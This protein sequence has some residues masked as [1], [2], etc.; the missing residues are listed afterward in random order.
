M[1]FRRIAASDFSFSGESNPLRTTPKIYFSRRSRSSFFFSKSSELT[2]AWASKL[3]SLSVSMLSFHS[4]FSSSGIPSF[5]RSNSTTKSYIASWYFTCSV[6]SNF[7][8]PIFLISTPSFMGYC[9]LIVWWYVSYIAMQ[10]C[11]SISVKVEHPQNG[12]FFC[13]P[14]WWRLKRWPFFYPPLWRGLKRWPFFASPSWW[15]PKRCHFLLFRR[16]WHLNL[17][18][19]GLIRREG[20][21]NL[22]GFG[23]IHR[24]D[25]QNSINFGPLYRGD[26][27]NSINFGPLHRGY[28]QNSINFGPL[29]RGDVQNSIN[30]GPLRRG[31]AQ[32]LINLEL[33][34]RGYA[35]NLINLEHLRR[36]EV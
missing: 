23:L 22:I 19:F 6:L 20:R 14:S 1:T 9:V 13:A 28:V 21:L 35:Q 27:Q 11:E 16:G 18:G 5:G 29:H 34:R 7:F 17:I 33:L 3:F 26:V 2:L 24:G 25:A 36:G 10:G 12:H 4:F 32:N 31:Y 8:V 30:L 15:D